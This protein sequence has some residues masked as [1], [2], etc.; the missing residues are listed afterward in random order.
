[1]KNNNIVI[2]VET[3]LKNFFFFSIPILVGTFFVPTSSTARHYRTDLNNDD[4]KVNIANIGKGQSLILSHGCS[5]SLIDAG[6][7][8][9]HLDH[10]ILPTRI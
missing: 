5:V 1:M 2:S 7:E 9:I 3:L 10:Y 4:T 6:G 8:S